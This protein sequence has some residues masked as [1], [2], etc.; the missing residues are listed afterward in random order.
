MCVSGSPV[1]T[2]LL[3]AKQYPWSVILDHM[4][5]IAH[6][7]PDVRYF[8]VLYDGIAL[9]AHLGKQVSGKL[10]PILQVCSFS[11]HQ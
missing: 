6:H 3:K 4:D 1:Q 2:V 7:F 10:N 5:C 8:F 11:S 9:A